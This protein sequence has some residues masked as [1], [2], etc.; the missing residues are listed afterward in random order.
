L[1]LRDAR[2]VNY[3]RLMPNTKAVLYDCTLQGG[4]GIYYPPGALYPDDESELSHIYE[5]YSLNVTV[6]DSD[7]VPIVGATIS[8][9]DANGDP[10]QRWVGTLQEGGV[11]N[12][13]DLTTDQ[14][15]QIS[16]DLLY[17]YKWRDLDDVMHNECHSPFTVT[18]T[19][20]GYVTKAVLYEMDDRHDDVETLEIWQVVE[21]PI[22]VDIAEDTLAADIAEDTVTGLVLTETIVGDVVGVEVLSGDIVEVNIA[23]NVE[24]Q[25]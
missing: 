8:I 12:V 14:Q 25:S 21:R 17:C 1:I 23:G 24:D 22:T 19:A 13:P 3:S 18:I 5:H 2:V 6:Q 10:G 15:G 11:E 20:K 16:T 9:R 7:G 4:I